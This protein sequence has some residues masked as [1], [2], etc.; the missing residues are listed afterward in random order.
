M[1]RC[2]ASSTEFDSGAFSDLHGEGEAVYAGISAVCS[3]TTPSYRRAWLT[4]DATDM[5]SGMSNLYSQNSRSQL[6]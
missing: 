2:R 6:V 4:G 1:R 5:S 3:L